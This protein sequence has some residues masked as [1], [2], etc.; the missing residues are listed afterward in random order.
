[1]R[2]FVAVFPPVAVQHAAAAA[3]EALRAPGDGVSWVKP[4][5]LHYTLRF[6]GEVGDDG[7]RRI[8][9]AARVAAA[10]CTPFEATLGGVGAFPNAHRARVL[11]IGMSAGGRELVMLAQELAAALEPR[12]FERER[13]AFSP[14]LTIGRV[15]DP[16][17][18]W[19][20]RLAAAPEID[21]VCAGFRVDRLCV[22]ESRLDPR[23]SVY[24]VREAAPLG[25]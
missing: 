7:A 6:I 19:V 1:L 15:R 21:P 13:K 3:I 20:P 25:G 24:T 23:G 8:T 9:E 4:D 14:H 17:E 11:W 22:V 10:Q 5:N 18:D 12:G 2:L 16:R